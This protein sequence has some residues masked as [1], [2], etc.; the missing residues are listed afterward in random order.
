MSTEEK[1]AVILQA[2][3]ERKALDVRV[4]DV[5]DRTQMTDRLVICTGTSNIHIRAVADR[6]LEMMKERGIK[7]IRCEGYHEARWVL[8]DFGDVVVHLFD[9]DDRVYYRLEEFWTRVV[10]PVEAEAP[11]T[12]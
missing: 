7:G 10:R 2:L 3:D 1:L 9:P 4:L 6:I 12:A 8:I 11:A 5:S